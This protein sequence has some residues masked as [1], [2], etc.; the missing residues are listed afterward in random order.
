[1]DKRMHLSP[2]A[3]LLLGAVTSVTW[4]LNAVVEESSMFAVIT[5]P[6]LVL[7]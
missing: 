7:R 5:G 4:I 3:W 2:K 1:M 6:L